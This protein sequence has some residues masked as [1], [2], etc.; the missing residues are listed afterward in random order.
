MKSFPLFNLLDAMSKD[1]LNLLE[2]FLNSP[3]WGTHRDALIFFQYLK[4]RL[5][6]PLGYDK[7]AI[8][9]DL[10]IAPERVYLLNNY[11]TAAVEQFL[12]C[13]EWLKDSGRQHLY[14]VK[15]LRKMQQNEAAIRMFD[16]ARRKLDA[17]EMK[18]IDWQYT[19][20]WLRQE[21]FSTSMQQGRGRDF[22]LQSLVNA[23]EA[24]FVAD[25]L[26]I[27]CLMLS[28]QA[29]A[30]HTYHEGLLPAVLQYLETGDLLRIPVIQG[31][32]HGYFTLS[33]SSN[34]ESHFI[35]LKALLDT[36]A[37][38][39]P[40][41]ER[42]DFFL[43]AINFCIRRINQ[44]DKNYIREVFTLYQSGL[45]Q[46]VL[47]E[48]GV[49]SRWTYNNIALS[50]LHLKEF[51]WTE[52]F[53][54]E[55]VHLLP[56]AHR[57]AA[58]HFNLAR[59]YYERRELQQAMLQLLH[60]EHDDVLQN[61]AAKAMLSRIYWELQETE[62]LY[63]Q[64]DSIHIYLRRQKVLGYHREVY[65]SFVKWMKKLLKTNLNDPVSV[66]QL[67]AAVENTTAL[68]EREWLLKQL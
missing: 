46:K 64:L 65:L 8:A 56:G 57:E 9:A 21:H 15:A 33:G 68:A 31:Y 55:Y 60:R 2:K 29:V 24:A 36:G 35:R 34:S 23:Q 6:Q 11:L 49:L 19:D 44:S 20:F 30:R 14:T 28:H 66:S 10:D 32:Y 43:M 40:V 3:F 16:Y 62:A 1:Q 53:L 26:R 48:N 27:G 47:L 17:D 52:R 39:L 5:G 63:N 13:T 12:A 42:Q 61:L 45:Q 51:E 54:K 37:E 58:L 25:R 67:R 22:N 41:A 50:A 18:G 7:K 59:L 38:Q 4:K